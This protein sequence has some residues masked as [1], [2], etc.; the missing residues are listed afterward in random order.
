MGRFR[1]YRRMIV[2]SCM[3]IS[4]GAASPA[5]RNPPLRSVEDAGH[6]ALVDGREQ[7]DVVALHLLERD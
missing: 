1:S 2:T 3:C 4:G 6:R 5:R 7:L